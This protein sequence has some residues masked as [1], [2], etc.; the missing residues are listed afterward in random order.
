VSCP[1]RRRFGVLCHNQR[2]TDTPKKTVSYEE[3]DELL[4]CGFARRVGRW[5]LQLHAP[6]DSTLKLH[7]TS[8]VMGPSAIFAVASGSAY[9]KAL[10]E[11]AW[12]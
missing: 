11:E 2:F 6:S 8:A 3:A 1:E 5:K 4:K 9:H 10:L 12:G 7:G